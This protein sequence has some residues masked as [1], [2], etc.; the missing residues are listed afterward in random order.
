MAAV[1]V[2]LLPGGLQTSRPHRTITIKVTFDYDFR[3]TPA[4]SAKV[5]QGCVQQFNL[6]EASLGIL[7]RAK[8]LS[9]PVPAGATGFVKGISATTEPYLFDSGQHRLA[10]S[11]Q[12]PNGLESDLSACTTIIKVP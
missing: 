11:A 7:R 1:L 8:L 2:S 6:Y 3:I 5:T 9:I 12:M 10:V 4:C